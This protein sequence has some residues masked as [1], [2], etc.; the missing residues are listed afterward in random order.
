MPGWISWIHRS[1]KAR[2]LAIKDALGDLDIHHYDE[3]LL[4]MP[5]EKVQKLFGF[6]T[7]G[8]IKKK[9]FLTNVIWQLHEI[10]QAATRPEDRPDFYNKRGFIRGMWYYIKT[11]IDHLPDF[12][13]DQSAIVNEAL[14]KI[15]KAGLLSYTD[16]NFR[17][18][19][20]EMRQLGKEN[21]HIIV[22]T[23]KDGF[24][25][26]MEDIHA[27]YGC[28][29]ITLG[30]KPSLLSSNYMVSELIEAAIDPTQ[31]FVC[32]SIVDFDPTGDIIAQSFLE[33]L[34]LSGLRTFHKFE[35]Y[36]NKNYER[37]DLIRPDNLPP[38]TSIRQVQYPLPRSEQ[39]P[40]WGRKTGG[41]DGKGDFKHGIEADEFREVQIQE[42]VEE[43]ILPYLRVG[44]A[45]VRRRLQL[46]KLK[47][48]LTEFMVYKLTH[49]VITGSRGRRARKMADTGS[50]ESTD[51]LSD[52]GF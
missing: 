27:N 44:A 8:R 51:G 29:V 21:P 47:E 46:R 48:V 36:H 38:G 32:L 9:L 50:A 3:D 4:K 10:I 35:Q 28:N 30:G 26:L 33:Q 41:V 34:K 37:L 18:R 7:T 14:T 12:K 16:F 1:K 52:G 45:V 25:S 40:A 5:L 13:G 22:F 6:P 17:D 15:V 11:R 2:A 42:L 24:I 31:E 19:D 23:E 39:K 43:A 49:P 20:A